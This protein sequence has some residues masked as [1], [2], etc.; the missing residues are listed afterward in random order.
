MNIEEE[1]KTAKLNYECL[2]MM[3]TPVDPIEAQESAVEYE[4]AFARYM[5]ARD[6][7]RQGMECI[8]LV[9]AVV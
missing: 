9:L 2:G 7:L 8:K 5:R 6:N 4:K 3:N 1:F